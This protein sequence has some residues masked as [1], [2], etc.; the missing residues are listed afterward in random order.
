MRTTLLAAL[1]V[2]CATTPPAP[3]PAPPAPPPA[4]APAPEKPKPVVHAPKAPVPLAEYFKIRR[5]FGASFSFD[6]SLVAYMSDEGGRM[7]VWAQP[8]AGGPAKQLT[9]VKDMVAGFWFSPT[10]DLVV[11]GADIGGDE[12]MQ[13]YTTD[14]SGREPVALFPDDPKGTRNDFVDWARD[15]KTFIY[16]S[17]RRDPKAQ[18]VYEYDLAKKKSSL[19]WQADG[20]LDAVLVSR[21]H[22]QLV[23]V[24]TVTDA[25]SNI[26]L[27][28]RGGKAQLL[29]PHSG[30]IGLQPLDFSPDGKSLLYVSDEGSEF[31]ALFS[32]DLASKKST[33]VL[34]AKWDVSNAGFSFSGRYLFTVVNDDGAPRLALG[35]A[36]TKKP[37]PLP[38]VGGPAQ[39]VAFSKSDRWFAVWLQ[40]DNAPASLWLIDLQAQKA[41]QLVDPLPP[42]LKDRRFAAATSVRVK[43]FDGQEVPAFLYQPEGP[44]PFPALIDVHGGPTAQSMRRFG[45][46]DQYLVSKGYAVLVPNVRGSTGYGKTWTKLDNKDLGGAPLK[47]IVACKQWLAANAKVDPN[48]VVV[49]GGSYGGYMALAAATFTPKEFAANVDI[50]GPSDL[51]SLVE[52]FPAYWAAFATFIYKKF[53]DPKDAADAQYQHDRSPLYFVERIERPLLVVQGTND[54]RVKKDQSD[55]IVEALKKRGVPVDYLVIEGEGHGFSKTE[56]YELVM[57]TTDRFLDKHVFGDTDVRVL[58]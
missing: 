42:S 7:D 48:R 11:F 21:D 55:R 33:P 30:E 57:Q 19:V 31:A 9:H 46:F 1:L 38:S 41:R 17:S 52:S 50:F 36:K 45:A 56:N 28:K 37:V 5:N 22:Q 40:A 20:K 49:F 4:A 29:T 15:G 18:D 53:G 27:V 35:D 32:M 24:E 10:Q 8:V 25:D 58:P 43:S 23:A 26:Y 16:K 14:S 3:P 34:Q 39:P 6:E 51:K 13:L 2:G 47:D 44:G 12:L 54:A